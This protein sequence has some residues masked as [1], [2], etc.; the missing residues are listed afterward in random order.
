M[1]RYDLAPGEARV[2]QAWDLDGIRL[3]VDT[4]RVNAVDRIFVSWSDAPSARTTVG[5]GPSVGGEVTPNDIA[6]FY[7]STTEYSVECAENTA[8][9]S[10]NFGQG[11]EGSV[12]VQYGVTGEF[13]AGCQ[14]DPGS[15]ELL[16]ELLGDAPLTDVTVST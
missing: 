8:F 16:L 14:D 4:D 3:V 9:T 6:S 11:P 5:R 15:S 12:T 13:G 2:T 10:F 1:E 7:G